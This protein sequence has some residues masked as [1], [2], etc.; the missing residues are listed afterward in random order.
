MIYCFTD[1]TYLCSVYEPDWHFLK[2]NY[3]TASYI[4]GKSVAVGNKRVSVYFELKHR[5]RRVIKR[6][7]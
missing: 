5:R 4:Y 7:S 3:F 6:E 1:R 2:Q